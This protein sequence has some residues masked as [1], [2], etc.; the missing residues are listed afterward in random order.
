MSGPETVTGSVCVR[1]LSLFLW[2]CTQ[3]GVVESVLDYLHRD[4]DHTAILSNAFLID[5]IQQQEKLSID[6]TRFIC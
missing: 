5:T 6:F 2:Q 1:R 4:S 3:Y